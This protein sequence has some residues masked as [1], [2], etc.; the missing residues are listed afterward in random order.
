MP[1]DSSPATSDEIFFFS[2]GNSSTILFDKLLGS[3]CAC[4]LFP[5][6]ILVVKTEVFKELD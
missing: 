2:N 4:V 6:P 3:V 5:P 1:Y